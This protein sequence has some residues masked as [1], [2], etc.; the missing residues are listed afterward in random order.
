M[1][2]HLDNPH[3]IGINILYRKSILY[4]HSIC[5]FKNG[6]ENENC[7][8]PLALAVYFLG[9]GHLGEFMSLLQILPNR[10]GHIRNPLSRSE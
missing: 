10:Q 8:Y 1:P 2:Q 4:G 6:N 7:K 3:R 9:Q 5:N